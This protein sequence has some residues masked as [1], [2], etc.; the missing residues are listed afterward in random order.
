MEKEQ[1]KPFAGKVVVITGA[2]SG[3]GKA[4]AM[5]LAKQGASL[6]LAARRAEILEQVA[7]DCIQLGGQAV[8]VTTDV[9]QEHS[10]LALAEAALA[11]GRKIDVWINNAGA[12]ALGAYDETPMAA[13]EQVI[14]INLLGHMRGS[15]AVL[16][17]FKLQGYGHLI[18]TI[19]LGAFAPMPYAV[20]YSASKYGLRG[21]SEALRAELTQFPGIQI[22]DVFPAF[23]DTPGFQHAGNY[24]GKKIKPAPPVYEPQLVAEAM[25]SLVRKPKPGVMVGSFGYLARFSNAL[26]PGSTRKFAARMMEQ[27]FEQA[28]SVPLTDGSL[29]QPSRVGTD[30]SGG[31]REPSSGKSKGTAAA[32]LVAGI[33]SVLF[34][35]SRR[36]ARLR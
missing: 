29:F 25:V 22:S 36:G 30:V 10:L 5:A 17:I 15:Y 19:S 32:L 26:F 27:Y 7:T 16:P 18:N 20:A 31:W 9:T 24:I 6:V 14:Q 23:I 4:T 21:F 3:I 28:D 8:A 1:I 11:F 13:H 35:F 34:Y 33:A 12:G 2:S